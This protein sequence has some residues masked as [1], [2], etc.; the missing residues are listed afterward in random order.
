[1]A[2]FIYLTYKPIFFSLPAGVL[3]S[4][5]PVC[6]AGFVFV[7]LRAVVDSVW[8][9]ASICWHV[10]QI[11]SAIFA[12]GSQSNML[13][14]VLRHPPSLVSEVVEA[15]ALAVGWLERSVVMGAGVLDHLSDQLAVEQTSEATKRL[16]TVAC[17][18]VDW[19]TAESLELIRA[20]HDPDWIVELVESRPVPFD[21]NPLDG[22]HRAAD[23]EARFIRRAEALL[24]D[25]SRDAS[26]VY[27]QYLCNIG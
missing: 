9:S 5:D 27:S 20:V 8:L 14:C 24:S 1:M 2:F 3:Q 15:A 16:L 23:Y 4:S 11:R 17:D 19:D 12:D 6:L 13:R 7:L 22:F 10:M 25:A 21:G 26:C 18:R